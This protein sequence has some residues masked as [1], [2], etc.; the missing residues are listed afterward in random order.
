MKYQLKVGDRVRLLDRPL[1]KRI[2]R[3]SE[4]IKGKLG[5][6]SYFIIWDGWDGEFGKYARRELI[7]LPNGIERAVRRLK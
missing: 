3:I 4:V 5:V 1:R 7:W 2:G 6:C